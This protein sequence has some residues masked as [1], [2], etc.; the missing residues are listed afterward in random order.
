MAVEKR[1]YGPLVDMSVS[2][3]LHH[4]MVF[5]GGSPPLSL[6]DIFG[7]KS[8]N[9]YVGQVDRVADPQVHRDAAYYVSLLP[10]PSSFLKQIDHVDQR[11]AGRRRRVI[12]A[13]SE[14]RLGQDH[15]VE[16]VNPQRQL[17]GQSDDQRVCGQALGC[18]IATV[19]TRLARLSN[20]SDER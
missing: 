14:S 18:G 16:T 7:Q 4:P 9:R 3:A 6:K 8:G 19:P 11:V 1:R 20:A 17:L 10:A 5:N 13:S 15:R 2:Q 12:R